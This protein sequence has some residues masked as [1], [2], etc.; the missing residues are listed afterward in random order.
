MGDGARAVLEL[1][2]EENGW[3]RWVGGREDTVERG[4]VGED[5]D[6]FV[7]HEELVIFDRC[8]DKV[9]IVGVYFKQ[10]S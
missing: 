7:R 3:V 2:E 10:E 8:V 1:G 6:E 5:G 9:I 4:D